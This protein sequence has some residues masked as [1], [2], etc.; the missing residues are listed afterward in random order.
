MQAKIY[1]NKSNLSA[2]RNVIS[3]WTHLSTIVIKRF[4]TEIALINKFLI[5]IGKNLSYFKHFI[6]CGEVE[7]KLVRRQ[8]KNRLKN[9]LLQ[10]LLFLPLQTVALLLFLLEIISS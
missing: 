10:F 6:L 1:L 4:G 5:V 7:K 3:K 8:N 2:T 9:L